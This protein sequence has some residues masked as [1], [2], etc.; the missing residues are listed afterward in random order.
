MKDLGASMAD[1]EKVEEIC[2]GVRSRP[3]LCDQVLQ[4]I[5]YGRE[6]ERHRVLDEVLSLP[7]VRVVPDFEDETGDMEGFHAEEASK[8]SP[9]HP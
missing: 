1:L 7:R 9:E 5:Q 8:E 2:G 3:I 4:G 6:Q